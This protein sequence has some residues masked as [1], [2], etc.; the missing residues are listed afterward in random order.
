TGFERRVPDADM[1]KSFVLKEDFARGYYNS[2]DYMYGNGSPVFKG[3]EKG[4][5]FK[6]P[7]NIDAVGALH[8]SLI[9]NRDRLDHLQNTYMS[10]I[11]LAYNPDSTFPMTRRYMIDYNF[12]KDSAEFKQIYES[13]EFKNYYAP[14]NL[15]YIGLVDITIGG[16]SPYA[17]FV[18]IRNKTDMKEFLDCLDRDFKAQ[19]FEDMASLK[20]GYATASINF[21]YKN[22]ASDTP[23]RLLNNSIS[24]KITKD[25]TNTIKWLEDHGYGGRFTQ[26]ANNIEYIEL[27]HFVADNNTSSQPIEYAS[28]EKMIPANQLKSLKVSDPAEIQKLLDTYETQNI[29]YNDYYYGTILYKGNSQLQDQYIDTAYEKEMAEKY[30]MDRST[31]PVMQIYFNEGNVPDYVLDYFK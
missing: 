10:S 23:E 27:Y 18:E 4:L 19:T 29:N 21:T 1:I 26:D 14:S 20:H 13:K 5:I 28:D 24:Y 3:N 15:N 2:Y 7:K 30:G 12:Y 9:S 16:D 25:Y 11:L 8:K 6:D 17:E 31:A 22:A